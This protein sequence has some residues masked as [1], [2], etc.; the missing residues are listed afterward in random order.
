MT[1][2]YKQQSGGCGC[3]LKGGAGAAEW[4][5]SAVGGIGQ[6]TALAGQGNLLSTKY[7]GISGGRRRRH[8]SRRRR[9]STKKRSGKM[10]NSIMNFM[11][12]TTRRRRSSHR[13]R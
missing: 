9:S 13:R 6:Q 4:V 1:R 2:S 8:A 12:T 11:R 10:L 5:A 3:G 7:P